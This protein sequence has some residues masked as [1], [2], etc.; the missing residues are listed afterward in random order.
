MATTTTTTTTTTLLIIAIF[1]LLTCTPRAEGRPSNEESISCTCEPETYPEQVCGSD[2]VTYDSLCAFMIASCKREVA[3]SLTI[4]NSGP[5][6]SKWYRCGPTTKWTVL[7]KK[8][9]KNLGS[10]PD[11]GWNKG[12]CNRW[13]LTELKGKVDARHILNYWSK[14]DNQVK[15]NTFIEINV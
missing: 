12:Y 13:L 14:N 6:P 3:F 1:L 15:V 10:C 2:G 11:I 7:V 4:E 8:A 5:C 9:Q